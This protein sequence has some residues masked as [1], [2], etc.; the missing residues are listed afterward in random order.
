MTWNINRTISL[1]AS[2]SNL[3]LTDIGDLNLAC[4]FFKVKPG[5]ARNDPAPALVFDSPVVVE[6]TT[7]VLTP[8]VEAYLFTLLGEWSITGLTRVLSV[9]NLGNNTYFWRDGNTYAISNLG[10]R[11][12]TQKITV[13]VTNSFDFGYFE[14]PV[15]AI[16]SGGLQSAFVQTNGVVTILSESKSCIPRVGSLATITLDMEYPN[17]TVQ[18][19]E[20]SF[21]SKTGLGISFVTYFTHKGQGFT[22]SNILEESNLVNTS[23]D[24]FFTI[25]ALGNYFIE[26]VSQSQIFIRPVLFSGQGRLVR[27]S[28]GSGNLTPVNGA[29][30]GSGLAGAIRLGSGLLATPIISLVGEGANNRVMLGGGSLATLSPSATGLGSSLNIGTGSLPLNNVEVTGTGFIPVSGSG[31]LTSPI[32]LVGTGHITN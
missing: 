19:N 29:L 10:K 13:T 22:Y 16:S 6:D 26:T 24:L 27:I 4:P 30:F 32:E 20:V 15:T 25:G 5:L 23:G 2:S 3:R 11:T 12:Y 14:F 17:P 28:K 31:D 8:V 7:T 9:N 1:A 21:F 18:A